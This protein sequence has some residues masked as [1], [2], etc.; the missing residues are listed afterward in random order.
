MV[1][2]NGKLNF[3]ISNDGSATTVAVGATTLA[4]GSWYHVTGVYSP[5]TSLTVYV[6]GVLDGI[7]TTSIPASIFNGSGNL[8]L[9]ARAGGTGKFMYGAIDEVKIFTYVR[10]P[11]QIAWEFNKGDPVARYKFDDCTESFVGNSALNAN[12]TAMGMDGTVVIVDGGSVITGLGDCGSGFAFSAWAVGTTGKFNASIGLDGTNDYVTVSDDAKLQFNS[13]TQDFSVFAWVKRGAT[14]TIHTVMSKE[15]AD[16][17]GWRMIINANDTVTCSV[18]STD[19]TSVST[20]DTGWHMVGCAIN[21]SGN[22]QMY[23]DGRA[24]GTAVA[25]SGLTMATTANLIIGARS[26][27][28]TD[29]FNGQIDEVRVYNY[30]V[31]ATQVKTIYNNDT[32]ARL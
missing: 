18:N 15:D 32:A 7:N 10:T 12:G 8:E 2:S 28:M 23:I 29:Y 14:G 25:T 24:N 16:N 27:T 1:D 5:S 3:E 21:R 9:G 31:S 4:T 22:G 17:D 6:N 20:I 26:Y 11:S 13:P 30:T 19:I